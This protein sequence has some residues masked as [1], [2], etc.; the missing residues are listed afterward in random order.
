M[1]QIHSPRPNFFESATYNFGNSRKSA[2]SAW[3]QTKRSCLNPAG[4][5]RSLFCE[6]IALQRNVRFADNPIFDKVGTASGFWKKNQKAR[7]K[8]CVL[9]RCH[10]ATAFIASNHPRQ[11]H[12]LPFR[13][14]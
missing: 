12:P 6:C 3:Y 2:M 11:D 5:E 1:V 13:A 8:S 14:S 10:S 7:F 4:R 9:P